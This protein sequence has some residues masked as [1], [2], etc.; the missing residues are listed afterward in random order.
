LYIL[1]NKT[2]HRNWLGFSYKKYTFEEMSELENLRKEVPEL[3]KKHL[4]NQTLID[5]IKKMLELCEE[6]KEWKTL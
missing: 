2:E 3:E 1:E 5:N 6:K 4:G